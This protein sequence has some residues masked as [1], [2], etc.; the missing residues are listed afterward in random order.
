MSHFEQAL[1]YNHLDR[2]KSDLFVSL[3]MALVAVFGEMQMPARLPQA[4]IKILPQYKI[5][6]PN[7]V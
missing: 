5:K 3:Q 1:Q 2:T 6:L 7:A 4:K